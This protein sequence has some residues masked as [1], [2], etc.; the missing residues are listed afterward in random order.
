MKLGISVV[1]Y[2]SSDHIQTLLAS[3]LKSS[4]CLDITVSVVCNSCDA[5]E[6]AKLSHVLDLFE[7][8]LLILSPTRSSVNGGYAKGNNQA[9]RRLIQQSCDVIWV[10][11]PDALVLKMEGRALQ[12]FCELGDTGIAATATCGID[13]QLLPDAARISLWTARTR[14]SRMVE[15]RSFNSVDYPAGHS[16]LFTAHAWS[17]L[18]GFNECFFLFCEEADLV[19]RARALEIRVG[20]EPGIIVTHEGGLSTGTSPIMSQ[21]SVLA[22]EAASESKI[23]FIGIHRP[24]RLSVVVITRL[25]Y[26]LFALFKSGVLPALAVFSGTMAGL[27]RLRLGNSSGGIVTGNGSSR[28][29][30]V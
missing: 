30:R 1:N 24:N 22:Y 15:S 20:F 14:P 5:K 25:A 12:S 18:N 16:M 10:L 8:K 7:G 4:G 3:I 29:R 28:V 13:G 2:F 9:V 23:L 27:R 17:K 26:A 21:K 6:F 11:N 19:L